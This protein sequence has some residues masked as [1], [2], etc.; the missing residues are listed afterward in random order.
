[1]S[2]RTVDRHVGRVVVVE[3]EGDQVE[4]R[5]ARRNRIVERRGIG[6]RILHR[7]RRQPRLERGLGALAEIGRILRKHDPV[8]RHRLRHQFAAVAAAGAH[9]EHL[10]ARARRGK[11][12]EGRRI[13]AFIGVAISIAA[14]GRGEQACVIRRRLRRG[15]FDRDA[16]ETGGGRRNRRGD[17]K[18]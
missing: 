6:D 9:I 11:S 15:A 7:R 17:Q 13:A 12:E 10:H 14:V 18:T 1:L 4:V 16:A 2:V 5:H 8:R 3:Q